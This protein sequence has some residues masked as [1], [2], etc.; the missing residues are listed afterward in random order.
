MPTSSGAADGNKL[1][2]SKIS[3][4]LIT[5]NSGDKYLLTATTPWTFWGNYYPT[6]VFFD[7][8]N[9]IIK[10][11]IAVFANTPITVPDGAVKMGIMFHP[12]YNFLLKKD[13]LPELD[14]IETEIIESDTIKS[15]RIRENY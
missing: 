8:A 6:V 15:L 3:S 2:M 4:C 10:F 13:T 11:A 1:F 9:V 12:D 5:V 14:S 7:L